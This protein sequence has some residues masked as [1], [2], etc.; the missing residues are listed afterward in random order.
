MNCV[1][2]SA[3]SA[4]LRGRLAA[5]EGHVAPSVRGR[6]YHSDF[7][8]FGPGLGSPPV[9][10]YF[11]CRPRGLIQVPFLYLFLRAVEGA[12]GSLYAGTEGKLTKA[13]IG[14]SIGSLNI[15][16]IPEVVA[17]LY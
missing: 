2:T 4:Q 3:V 13:A 15:T 12:A 9:R 10:L 1:S 16:T 8:F 5:R 7:A 17:M 11:P 14:R 6:R